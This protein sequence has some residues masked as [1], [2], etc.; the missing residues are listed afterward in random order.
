MARVEILN[1]FQL[2]GVSSSRIFPTFLVLFKMF[3][4]FL[5]LRTLLRIALLRSCFAVSLRQ[6]AYS[7]T[8]SLK[9][10]IINK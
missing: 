3:A 6:K 7:Y 1:F 4:T 2:C 9:L 8:C 10:E 5:G